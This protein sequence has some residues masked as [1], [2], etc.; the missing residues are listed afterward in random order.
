MA[1]LPYSQETAYDRKMENAFGTLRSIDW[2]S[3]SRI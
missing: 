1:L 2:K 3:D